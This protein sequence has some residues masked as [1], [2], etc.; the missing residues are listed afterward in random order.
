M[1][2]PVKQT[3]LYYRNEAEGSDKIYLVTIDPVAGGKFHVNG[4]S[5]P[6][7]GKLK[8]RPQTESGPVLRDEAEQLFAA[9]VDKKKTQRKTPYSEGDGAANY[10]P[11]STTSPADRPDIGCQ[12]LTPI[13]DETQVVKIIRGASFA[14]QEKFDGERGQL[15]AERSGIFVYNRES[16]ATSIS[17]LIVDEAKRILKRVGPF[18]ID[19]E[20]LRDQFVAFDCLTFDGTDIR[21]WTMR[22]R[23]ETLVSLTDGDDR[24]TDPIF[25][26]ETGFEHDS[27]VVMTQ[28]LYERGAEGVVAKRIDDPYQV[29]R[30]RE[31]FKI[32]FW[33]TASVLVTGKNAKDSVRIGV[34]EG[35]NLIDIGNVKIRNS[36]MV[37][38]EDDVIEVRYLNCKRGGS[39]YQP[40]MQRVRTDI[41]APACVLSQIHFKGE[42]RAPK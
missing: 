19:G 7:G 1:S 10:V 34:F 35:G 22:D 28:R 17:S 4:W 38:K 25:I 27:K 16:R 36:R 3:T 8:Q 18:T 15:I 2:Q 39:L 37:V 14:I 6:R 9:L 26:A 32:K 20:A 40:L 41:Q 5:G 13:E 42:P 31:N 12:L 23:H 33:S 24:A 21:P 11:P 29:G 30:S